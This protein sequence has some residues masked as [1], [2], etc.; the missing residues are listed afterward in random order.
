MSKMR[1]VMLVI[2]A[3][4]AIGAGVLAKSFIKSNRA[5]ATANSTTAEP[6]IIDE[7]PKEQILVVTK[8]L[9]MGDKLGEGAIAWQ[10]WPKSQI[11]PSMITMAN[12]ANAL[13]ELKDAR[14][15]YAMY[16]GELVLEK[17]IVLVGDKGFMSAILPKGMRA[18]SVAVTDQTTAGG[19]I[20][21]NDRVDVILTRKFQNPASSTAEQLVK[22]EI[23]LSNVRILAINQTY[24]QEAEGNAVTVAEGKTATLEL[25][26][27]Q[28]EVI[29]KIEASGELSLALRSIAESDGKV[30]V[31][32]KPVLA[33]AYVKG[34]NKKVERGVTY[35][36]SGLTSVAFPNP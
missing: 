17:K 14:A 15:R 30:L 29:A 26:P 35:I 20:L 23:V 9:L 22:S 19:F 6:I 27:D 28:S 36:R 21:P 25:S 11:Q 34:P 2:A 3:G 7:T 13:E 10:D 8:D 16:Q 5:V 18:I 31:D 32:E 24:R 4:A 12:R 33:E 1:I